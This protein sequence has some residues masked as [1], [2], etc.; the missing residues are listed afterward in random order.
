LIRSIRD[1]A[2]PQPIVLVLVLVVVLVLGRTEREFEDEAEF[3]DEDGAWESSST[4]G[5]C[6]ALAI[7]TIAWYYVY[8][9]A[10]IQEACDE[11]NE[12]RH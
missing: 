8:G 5:R 1:A 12:H 10:V 9:S 7:H 6:G 11:E 3:E 4:K 2:E